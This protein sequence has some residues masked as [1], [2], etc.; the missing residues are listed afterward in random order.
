VQRRP[1]IELARKLLGWEPRIDL[2]QGL[3]ATVDY[4]RGLD[5]RSA[6]ARGGS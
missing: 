3:R 6:R 5:C 4:F 2:D 1:D